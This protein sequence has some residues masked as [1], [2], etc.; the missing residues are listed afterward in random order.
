MLSAEPAGDVI[1]T[2][3]TVDDAAQGKL[4][5]CKTMHYTETWLVYALCLKFTAG[6]DYENVTAELTFSAGPTQI[7]CVNIT[8]I[9]DG[10]VENSIE[11]F[12]V[13]AVNTSGSITGLPV[14]VTIFIQDMDRKSQHAAL[15]N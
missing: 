8:I 10:A 9:M 11:R 5:F 14:S 12:T 4:F 7:Q 13:Q 3:E 1:V 6:S 15:A 2:L